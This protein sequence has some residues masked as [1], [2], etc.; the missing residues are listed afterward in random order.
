MKQT[1]LRIDDNTLLQIFKELPIGFSQ[2]AMLARQVGFLPGILE[3]PR[4]E[5]PLFEHL[6]IWLYGRYV[7]SS[8]YN[9]TCRT[10]PLR[11][12]WIN[13]SISKT[14]L[15]GSTLSTTQKTNLGEA[16][17]YLIYGNFL[18]ANAA[19]PHHVSLLSL[20]LHDKFGF[21]DDPVLLQRMWYIRAF[22]ILQDNPDGAGPG[23]RWKWYDHRMALV[24]YSWVRHNRKYHVSYVKHLV[25]AIDTYTAGTGMS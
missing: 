10:H 9:F 16:M 3:P 2:L 7:V 15:F 20:C 4:D 6:M 5:Y 23:E 19:I 12:R 18:P 25:W 1:S 8:L 13:P 24:I 21:R 17:D 22:L 11:N 14:T